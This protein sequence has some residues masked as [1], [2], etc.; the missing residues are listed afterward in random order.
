MSVEVHPESEA[1]KPPAVDDRLRAHL[2]AS[3]DDIDQ[4]IADVEELIDHNAKLLRASGG[5][6]VIQKRAAWPNL[7]AP[8]KH[9]SYYVCREHGE[10]GVDVEAL[11]AFAA[12]THRPKRTYWA[13]RG[14]G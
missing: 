10:I 3:H 1:P 13:N 5:G 2:A 6:R 7:V 12:D 9:L 14:V 8:I 11:A 4:L